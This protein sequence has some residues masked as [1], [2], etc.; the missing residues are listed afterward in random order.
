MLFWFLHLP[1]LNHLVHGQCQPLMV[2]TSVLA[3][4]FC[5]NQCINGEAFLELSDPDLKEL[6]IK[7]GPRKIIT[8][9]LQELKWKSTVILGSFPIDTVH[10]VLQGEKVEDIITQMSVENTATTSSQHSSQISDEIATTSSAEILNS[11]SDLL[12]NHPEQFSTFSSST[13]QLPQSEVNVNLF[14]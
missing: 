1:T 7:M 13:Q 3:T 10:E 12:Q 9:F 8:K 4:L 2:F 14:S 6:G 11:K 5:K